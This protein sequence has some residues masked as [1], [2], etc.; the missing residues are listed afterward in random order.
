MAGPFVLSLKQ[1]Q[2]QWHREKEDKVENMSSEAWEDEEEEAEWVHAPE[3]RTAASRGL[4]DRQNLRYELCAC[5][6]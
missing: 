3:L 2:D 6:C 4:Q 5:C 1:Q